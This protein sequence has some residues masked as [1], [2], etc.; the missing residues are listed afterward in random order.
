MDGNRRFCQSDFLNHFFVLLV[1]QYNDVRCFCTAINESMFFKD[2][3]KKEIQEKTM[4][5]Y[6][7][8]RN[9]EG[10]VTYY[11][12]VRA[13]TG[14]GYGSEV[15]GNVTISPVPG[16]FFRILL[17]LFKYFYFLVWNSS[18]ELYWLFERSHFVAILLHCF[19]S[20]FIFLLSQ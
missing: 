16:A 3:F 7:V 10:N 20:F 13:E 12:S 4:L 17:I 15:T 19:F 11:F 1:L 2:E 5:T 8:A 14:V 18:F 6:H 9:L